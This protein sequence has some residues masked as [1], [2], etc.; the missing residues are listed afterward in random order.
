[1]IYE[2]RTYEVVPGRM[3]ALHKR[4]AETTLAL[5]AKHGIKVVGFWTSHIG[6][7]TNQLVYMVAF[8]DLA[9][10]DACWAAFAAD[11]EWQAK[12]AE[13]ERDGPIVANVQN[14]ILRPTP[15]SPVTA[16]T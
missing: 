13:S 3:P 12:R 16:A 8:D 11:P 10:R 15:Y 7:S 14:V 9:Q 5:F 1:M 2:L 6:G 4:F